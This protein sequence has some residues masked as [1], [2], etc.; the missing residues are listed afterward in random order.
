MSSY[1]VG[2]LATSAWI[3]ICFA[4]KF[5]SVLTF[6]FPHVFGFVVPY[7]FAFVFISVFAIV[8]VSV[9]AIGGN[10]DPALC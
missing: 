2:G 3:C 5:L 1:N 7:V 6:V 8:S 4:F 10:G 9:F